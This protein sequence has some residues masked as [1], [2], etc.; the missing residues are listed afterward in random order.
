[1]LGQIYFAYAAVCVCVCMYVWTR[2]HKYVYFCH[3]VCDMYMHMY[4]R[5]HVFMFTFRHLTSRSPFCVYYSY[6]DIKEFGGKAPDHQKLIELGYAWWSKEY[7]E[8]D[9]IESCKRKKPIS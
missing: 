9:Y 4:T 8:L 3:Y 1:M 7:P 5:I 6:G 2:T